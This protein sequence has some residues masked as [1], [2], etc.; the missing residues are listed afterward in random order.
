MVEAWPAGLDTLLQEGG[1]PLSAG[2]K[3]LLALA[4]A[5]LNPSRVLVLDEATANVDVETDAVIQRTMRTEFK[6][7]TILAI[8]HRLH[9]IIDYDKVLVLDRGMVAEF[10]TPK[11]LLASA[12]GIFTSMVD[13]TGEATSKFLKGVALG[14]AS[15]HADFHYCHCPS[16]GFTFAFDSNIG[17]APQVNLAESMSVAV[18]AGMEKLATP[19]GIMGGPAAAGA[20]GYG[21][22]SGLAQQWLQQNSSMA[23]VQLMQGLA[24][25]LL[26]R[27][28]AVTK[29]VKVTRSP[30]SALQRIILD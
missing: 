9:T 30:S 17:L 28:Q 13:D 29:M 25:Q 20:V 23:P 1:A 27:S 16:T 21:G 24:A 4:R 19:F 11:D 8:A 22:G 7:R 14:K 5:Q 15:V 3:Q 6:D 2:Q 26:E 10:G 12:N 18:E